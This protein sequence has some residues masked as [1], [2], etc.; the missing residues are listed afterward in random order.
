MD[1]PGNDSITLEQG[2]RFIAGPFGCLIPRFRPN[3]KYVYEL[4]FSQRFHHAGHYIG[5]TS[6]LEVRLLL[7]RAGKGAKLTRAVVRAGIAVE[8]VRLWKVESC[9]EGHVLER[10]LKNWHDG[11]HWCPICQHKPIDFLVQLR[12]GKRPFG[13]LARPGKRQPMEL[14]R[15]VFVRR[16]I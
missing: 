16:R 13:L 12:Q 2:E 9:E 6:N 8:L 14:S 10:R 4:H 11:A 5:Y 15:P 3:E 7:H 1:A